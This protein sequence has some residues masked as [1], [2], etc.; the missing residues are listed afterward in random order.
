[1]PHAICLTHQK[2]VAT[3]TQPATEVVHVEHCL[4]LV[5][6]HSNVRHNKMAEVV[7]ESCFKVAYFS[8]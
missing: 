5:Q 7:R 2:V 3:T 6:I 1:M 8:S 4:G